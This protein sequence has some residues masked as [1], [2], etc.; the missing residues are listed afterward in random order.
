MSGIIFQDSFE[1][2]DRSIR[3]DYSTAVLLRQVEVPQSL[4]IMKISTPM[5]LNV[6]A[7]YQHN[8]RRWSLPS[9]LLLVA[10]LS[11]RAMP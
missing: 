5:T 8:H 1:D 11:I 3:R 9:S 10:P 7:I 2:F 4:S 6:Q